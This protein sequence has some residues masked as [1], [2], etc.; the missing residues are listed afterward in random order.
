ML[1][2]GTGVTLIL[3]S[4]AVYAHA[5]EQKTKPKAPSISHEGTC[6]LN[7]SAPER[8]GDLSQFICYSRK[9]LVKYRC[10]LSGEGG[11]VLIGKLETAGKIFFSAAENNGNEGW[12]TCL[13]E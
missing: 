7:D 10:D 13:K 2:S 11:N 9:K 6:I 5:E 8:S 3:L 12:F 1:K 4:L